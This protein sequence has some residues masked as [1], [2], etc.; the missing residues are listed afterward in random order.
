MPVAALRNYL[1]LESSAGVPVVME[2]IAA[3]LVSNSPMAGLYGRLPDVPLVIALDFGHL[4]VSRLNV[5]PAMISP[6]AI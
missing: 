4:E 6:C 1:R 3:L 2:T 5:R